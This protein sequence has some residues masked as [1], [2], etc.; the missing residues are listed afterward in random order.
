M[1]ADWEAPMTTVTIEVS[2]VET[3]KQWMKAA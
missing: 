1:W 2:G 3:T